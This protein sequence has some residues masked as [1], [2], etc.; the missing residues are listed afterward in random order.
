M[1]RLVGTPA[2]GD[3]IMEP[4][5]GTGG[6]LRAPAEAMRDL[7]RDPSTIELAHS[8]RRDKLMPHALRSA[9]ALI[10]KV[11]HEDQHLSNSLIAERHG[12]R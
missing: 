12:D 1:A 3:Q 9:E 8:I 7:G 5:A 11:D 6:L 2:E 4:A 10:Q